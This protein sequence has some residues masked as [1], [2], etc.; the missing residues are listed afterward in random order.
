MEISPNRSVAASPMSFHRFDH[1]A[2][3][4]GGK[5]MLSGNFAAGRSALIGHT[6]FVGSN[7]AAQHPFDESFNSKNIE[8][9]AGRRFDLLVV[10]GMPAAMWIAN[11]EPEAD[12]AVL[13]RLSSCVLQAHAAQVVIVSTVGVYTTPRE[14][15]EDSAIAADSQTPYGRH[16]LMLEQTLTDRFPSALSVRLPALF[17]PG[18]KK[19]A[20]YDL[21]H[22]NEVHKINSAS[23]YQFYNLARLSADIST[24]LDAD[25]RLVNFATEPVSVQEVARDAFGLDFVNDPGLPPATSICVPSMLLYSAGATNIFIAEGRCSTNCGRL[26]NRSAATERPDETSSLKHRLARRAG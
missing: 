26:S 20:V 15:D 17:G 8:E 21:L 19:N 1:A 9:I 16:R 2:A 25:L 6:G 18:L 7:L 12:R 24:A 5:S 13:D 3:F 14:V 10:S 22:Q 4:H 11:R 23:V